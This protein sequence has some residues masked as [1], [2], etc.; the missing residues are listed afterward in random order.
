MGIIKAIQK[1]KRICEKCHATYC[2]NGDESEYWCELREKGVEI[3]GLCEFCRPTGKY[4]LSKKN[5]KS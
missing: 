3:N 5:N 4:S 2:I 1:N